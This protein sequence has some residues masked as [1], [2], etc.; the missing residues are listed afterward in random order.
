MPRAGLTTDRVVAAAAELA[1]EV[2]FDRLSVSALARGFGV[3]DASLYSHVRNLQDLRERVAV[4][5]AAEFADRLATAVA[6]RSRR[7]ALLAFADA[8]RGFGLTHPGRYAACQLPLTPDRTA[9]SPGHLRLVETTAAVLDAYGLPDPDRTDAVRLLRSTFHG[10]VSI[11]A[12]HGFQHPRDVDE[13]FHRIVG[14]LDHLLEH[15][16]GR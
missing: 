10:Y 9:A 8:Y 1:D 12:T 6:G 15:W 11:Q 5:A 7:D 2:G 4:L 16:P 3:K 14:A 13:S